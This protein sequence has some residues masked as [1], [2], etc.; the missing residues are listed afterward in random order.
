MNSI[1]IK[2]LLIVLKLISLFKFSVIYL[3]EIRFNLNAFIYN[4]FVVLAIDR[5]N[6]GNLMSLVIGAPLYYIFIFQF[7]AII[8]N[9]KHNKTCLYSVLWLL[10]DESVYK[11]MKLILFD[12]FRVYG[13]AIDIEIFNCNFQPPFMIEFNVQL[14]FIKQ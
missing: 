12:L 6:G 13:K 14:I 8:Y 3:C 5:Y 1:S 9:L 2:K 10:L 11:T 7:A 4:C